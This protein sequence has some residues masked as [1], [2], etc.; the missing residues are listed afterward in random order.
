[1][2]FVECKACHI[3][4]QKFYYK[5]SELVRRFGINAKGVLIA[6]TEE[7]PSYDTV[8]GNMQQ[9]SCGSKMDIITIWDRNEI[10]DI[11]HTLLQVMNGD[12][13]QKEWEKNV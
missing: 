8:P 7:K 2:L 13:K 1:M 11:G 9:R 12:Y 4:E 6:D 10:N 5:L 3:I